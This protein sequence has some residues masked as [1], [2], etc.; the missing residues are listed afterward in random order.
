MLIVLISYQIDYCD[1]LFLVD[2]SLFKN[3]S[4]FTLKETEMISALFLWGN[5]LLR[6][7]L[8]KKKKKKKKMQK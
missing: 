3:C 6:A 1:E 5:V 4:N 7:E 8:Q 2:D